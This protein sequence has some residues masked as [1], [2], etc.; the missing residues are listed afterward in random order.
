MQHYWLNKPLIFLFNDLQPFLFLDKRESRLCNCTDIYLKCKVRKIIKRISSNRWLFSPCKN[1][2]CCACI[3]YLR[4]FFRKYCNRAS[5]HFFIILKNSIVQFFNFSSQKAGFSFL[6]F[7]FCC[8]YYYFL[9]IIFSN[10]KQNIL[11][12]KDHKNFV[13][14]V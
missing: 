5:R 13:S 10:F 7:F 11:L 3:K 8:Y 9:I 2:H 1:N 14:F 4:A 12:A 6:F